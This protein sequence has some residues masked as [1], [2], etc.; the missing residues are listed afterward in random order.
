MSDL[1]PE[2]LESFREESAKVLAEL[3]EV[4]EMLEKVRGEFPAK[5]LEDYSQKIDRIMG[6]AKTIQMT[7]PDNVGL[8]R[9][10]KMSEL[11]KKLGYKAAERKIPQLIPIFAAFWADVIEVVE[12]LINALEDPVETESIATNYSPVLQKRLEWLASKVSKDNALEHVGAAAGKSQAITNDIDVMS[13]LKD[14]GL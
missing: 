13:L 9:I 11:C 14:L 5:L 2:I 8:K 1:D 4:V 3:T 7:A 12:E 10:S 6:A